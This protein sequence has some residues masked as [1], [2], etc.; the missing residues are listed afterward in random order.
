MDIDPRAA[1]IAS[2][3]LWLRAQR[4]WHEAGVKAKDRPPI[5]RGHVVAAIAPPAERELCQQFAAN[6]DPLD[7][8]L[9]EK[10][11]S[12]L[13]GLPEL[14][15]LLQVERELPRLVREVYGEHGPL[16]QAEDMEQ[17][18]KAETRLRAAL[19]AFTHAARTTYQGRLFA[20]DA[21]QGLRLIDLCRE[22]FDVVVMN[23]PF[24][25]LAANTKDQLTKA[26]PRSKNDLLAIM[27]ERGLEL[28]RPGGRI[29]AI[30]SR[31]CF[32][33]SSFQKW[34]E[35]VVLGIAQPEVMA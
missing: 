33:L 21:L 5:G 29:G 30:T 35:E 8:E 15:V 22:V 9:F 32:F 1:Q 23:P 18:R 28:L 31:T 27:V 17:W 6:L 19:T 34:R 11:L 13:K 20:Q 12:V 10:T 24:G 16:F 25:A 4:A 14:G 2:L 3:A 7:A 26:Y